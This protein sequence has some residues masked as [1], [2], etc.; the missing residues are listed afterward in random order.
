MSQRGVSRTLGVCL[1]ASTISL[2]ERFPEGVRAV[3]VRH[4]GDVARVLQG[5]TAGR[6]PARLGIT[7]RKSRK[8]FDLPTVSELEAIELAYGS[9]RHRLPPVDCVVSAGGEAF[10]VYG[11]DAA[12]RIRTVHA[13]NKCA[14]GTGE[15]FLQQLKRMDLDPTEA[16]ALAASSEGYPVAG[17]CSVFCKSDCTHAMNKGVA[18]GRICAGLAQMMADKIIDLLRTA[19]AQRPLV[20]GGVTQNPV[21]MDC[22]RHAFPEMVIPG[23]AAYFEALGALLWAEDSG[24]VVQPG[25][26]VKTSFQSFTFLPRLQEGAARVT[27]QSQP[28]GEYYAGDYLVGLDVGSTTTKAVLV[29][30]D[31]R[32]V[33][34]S[35]YLRTN[36]DPVLASRQCY[37]QLLEQSRGRPLTI[38]GV[39]VTGS[40]RQ[41]AAI[42]ALSDGVVNEILAHATAAVHFDPDV[43]TIFEIGGQDAKYTFLTNQVANDY[44]MNEACSAGTGSF[45]EEACQEALG[46]ATEQIAAIAVEATAPPNFSDQCA[47]FI[48]SDIKTAVQ[49]GIARADIVAGLVYSVCQNY[50]NRVKGNRPVG[51]KILM[52]GGVC[53]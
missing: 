38:I 10:L 15:F 35:T 44:A 50:L 39:G 4:G 25:D 43:E 18:K 31:N 20:I 30:T 24:P 7:G 5:L 36:G 9:L 1:G 40:G 14:S 41:I 46:I 52:Q 32:T 51:K 29:R 26:L 34:A 17:R 3:G 27:F 28:R 45:L 6:L 42:H 49:E 2:V 13:G 8:F 48:G 16:V 21:V 19:Q 47:A 33:V 12:G 37:R 53:Y 22:L 11:L 23:E